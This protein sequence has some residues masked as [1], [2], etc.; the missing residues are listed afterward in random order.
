MALVLSPQGR[1]VK[2]A[3]AKAFERPEVVEL[4]HAA[5]GE[6]LE[7][8]LRERPGTVREVMDSADG[9]VFEGQVQRHG[10][11]DGVLTDASLR[12][13]RAPCEVSK[14]V[15]EMAGFADDAASPGLAIASPMVASESAGIH[16]H[17][18]GLRAGRCKQAPD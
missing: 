14:Q 10:V 5:V 18:E 17:H 9:S 4:K 3:H 7:A 15:N 13:N 11:V 16:R 12:R 6:H 1:S 2:P 8:L